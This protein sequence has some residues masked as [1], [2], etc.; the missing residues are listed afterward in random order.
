MQ[1]L[2][3]YGKNGL[4][5][6]VPDDAD[7]I[8]PKFVAGIPD[9]TAGLLH[10]LRHPLVARPLRDIADQG[11]D[12]VIVFP[13]R[14]RPMPS[15][16][17]LPSILSELSHLPPE[18]ITLLNALGLHRPNS[19]EELTDMLGADIVGRY[20]ILQH[21]PEDRNMLV[22]SRPYLFRSRDLDQP[23]ISGGQDQGADRLH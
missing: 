11:D 5:V 17:V 10:A 3:A 6:N 16:R 14:S 18:S 2:L 9:E 23:D 7:V 21:N 22:Q 1:V 15:S 13:D 19:R 20:R 4:Q 12:V 8:T